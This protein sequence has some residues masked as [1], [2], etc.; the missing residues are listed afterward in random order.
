[1]VMVCCSIYDSKAEAWL[2]P[3]FF[4]AAGQA[5]RSFSD[6]INS[7]ETEFAKHPEDY[8]I[9][10]IGK[11][12]QRTGIFDAEVPPTVLS[13]GINMVENRMEVVDG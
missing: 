13:I 2:Q 7:K 10:I 12:D 8:S 3:M 4:Q 11:F 5:I 6:V 9:F 1:M